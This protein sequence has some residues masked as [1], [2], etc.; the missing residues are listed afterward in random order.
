MGQEEF[1]DSTNTSTLNGEMRFSATENKVT[2]G[3]FADGDSQTWS[4]P[5]K[6]TQSA[7]HS[8]SYTS[9]HATALITPEG[10]TGST[11]STGS[12]QT[13]SP[14]AGTPQQSVTHD[15]STEDAKFRETIDHD[16]KLQDDGTQYNG[17]G[18]SAS[19]SD[20]F[21]AVSAGS[22]HSTSDV[23]TGSLTGHKIT[24][25][26]EEQVYE[27]RLVTRSDAVKPASDYGAPSG[28]ITQ[29]LDSK[30]GG[31]VTTDNFDAGGI[32][33]L[34][35]IAQTETKGDFQSKLNSMQKVTYASIPGYPAVATHAMNLDNGASFVTAER[36]TTT[37]GHTATLGSAKDLGSYKLDTSTRSETT[38]GGSASQE[39]HDIFDEE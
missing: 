22:S 30:G 23:V 11:G 20:S 8:G 33:T 1:E 12:P 35:N 14:Q 17:Q 26:V 21:H 3:S 7:S 10:S 6:N 19:S 36:T 16:E 29:T 13:G 39:W 4:D 27:S 5:G 18:Y 31:S 25:H 28:N 15:S 38:L 37:A 34:V 9:E 24:S 2:S 32:G